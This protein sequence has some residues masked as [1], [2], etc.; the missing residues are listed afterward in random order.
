[1]LRAYLIL[2]K[3]WKQDSLA[4][5]AGNRFYIFPQNLKK[6]FWV[7]KYGT[8]SHYPISLVEPINRDNGHSLVFKPK[9]YNYPNPVKESFTKLRFYSSNS[10]NTILN[11][12]N[13]L[14]ANIYSYKIK[15]LN[16]NDYNEFAIDSKIFDFQSGLYFIELKYTVFKMASRSRH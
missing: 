3:S 8:Y 9:A 7:T 12:Y 15:N 11:I 6:T 2:V 1:M 14:G 13:S 4:V 10:E 16:I 5:V